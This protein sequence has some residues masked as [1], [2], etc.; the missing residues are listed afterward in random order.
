MLAMFVIRGMAYGMPRPSD[1]S[2]IADLKGTN[3]ERWI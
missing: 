2:L 1:E 3:K